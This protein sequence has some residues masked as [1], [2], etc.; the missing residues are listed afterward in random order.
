MA[1]RVFDGIKF[2]EQFL[3]RFSQGTF[4]PSL[5]QIGPA[6][7]EEKILKEIVDDAWRT[8]DTAPPKKLPLSTLCSGE[9]KTN[10]PGTWFIDWCFT[11]L[12][13]VS[14]SYNGSHHSC[15]SWVSPVLG[16]GSE[17]SCPRILPK[18]QRIQFASNPGPLDYKSISLPLSHAG[19][20][21]V[22]GQN[23]FNL[24]QTKS[25]FLPVYRH[26]ITRACLGKG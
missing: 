7:W 24:F 14:Q 19:P 11:P 9:L 3:K 23:G 2:C 21:V 20:C 17:V 22:L 13:T 18:I 16:W 6:V 25:L 12:S 5:V 8:T 26:I 10:K 1:I 15:L 4:L